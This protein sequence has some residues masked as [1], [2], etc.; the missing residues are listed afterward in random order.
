MYRVATED[1]SSTLRSRGEGPDLRCSA[2]F[3][4]VVETLPENCPVP[5]PI[6]ELGAL[7]RHVE[8]ASDAFEIDPETIDIGSASTAVVPPQTLS[9]VRWLLSNH[10]DHLSSHEKRRVGLLCE[11]S[12]LNQ[13]PAAGESNANR[14]RSASRTEIDE[15][16]FLENHS[17]EFEG[18]HCGTEYGTAD[19]LS[20]HRSECAPRQTETQTTTSP[21]ET[22]YSC[23]YCDESFSKKL[24]LRVHEKR[25]C[26]EKPSSKSSSTN[27][28][29]QRPAF[30]KEIRKDRGSERVSG[31]SPFADA[32][33]L[34]DTGI[35]QGGN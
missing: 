2:A 17:R 20:D 16:L 13:P 5:A 27:S 22:E 30:G 26:D 29:S 14:I 15:S 18:D 21:D 35:H 25:N 23:E 19:A 24:S 28:T 6:I 7:S 3:G 8:P 31:R 10:T 34:K 33:K 1:N 12:S 4:A 9:R 11:A 32:D